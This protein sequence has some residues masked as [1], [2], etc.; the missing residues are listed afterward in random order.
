MAFLFDKNLFLQAKLLDQERKRNCEPSSLRLTMPK[1]SHS[2]IPSQKYS[3]CFLKSIFPCNSQFLWYFCYRCI[4]VYPSFIY[5]FNQKKNSILL[6][7]KRLCP[8]NSNLLLRTRFCSNDSQC[9]QRI[10]GFLKSKSLFN[11]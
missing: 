1:I 7:L 2:Y 8:L 11:L 9:H 5:C 4:I 6:P 3:L 10:D